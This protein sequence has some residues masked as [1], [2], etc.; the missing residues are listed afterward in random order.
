MSAVQVEGA[1]QTLEAAVRGSDGGHLPKGWPDKYEPVIGAVLAALEPGEKAQRAWRIKGVG[2]RQWRKGVGLFLVT[3]RRVL[4]ADQSSRG[5]GRFAVAL[6]DV[7]TVALVPHTVGW[8]ISLRGKD[9]TVLG[10]EDSP[11][12]FQVFTRGRDPSNWDD[13]VRG[14]EDLEEVQG[15]L[16]ELLPAARA[17]TGESAALPAARAV[18]V[19]PEEMTR[20]TAVAA[21]LPSP[22]ASGSGG[23]KCPSCGSA[24][25]GATDRP[26]PKSTP[27]RIGFAAVGLAMLF[28][29]LAVGRDLE[30]FGL[31]DA[32]ALV[33]LLYLVGFGGGAW[34]VW[35]AATGRPAPVLNMYL[36]GPT[37]QT[38]AD[39]RDCHHMWV[40]P[41]EKGSTKTAG[42]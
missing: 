15:S 24:N 28:V 30:F 16:V 26:V 9:E 36:A 41:V 18:P 42:P 32:G 23:P 14:E 7:A 3:D 10:S 33:Y 27:S 39:C 22:A 37:W 17:S 11:A 21:S 31:A 6:S 2:P 12:E 5:S 34:L 8:K 19:A 35:E 13:H 38:H 40:T 20:P 25:T 29:T 1:S 4:G